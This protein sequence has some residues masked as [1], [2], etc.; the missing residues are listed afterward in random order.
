MSVILTGWRD[1]VRE[2]QVAKLAA[3]NAESARLRALHKDDVQKVIKPYMYICIYIC[4]YIY[5]YI[6]IYIYIYI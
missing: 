4:I 5:M 2:G 1:V 3:T 6:Y